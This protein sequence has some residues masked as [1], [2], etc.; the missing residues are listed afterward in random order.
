MSNKNIGLNKAV[1]NLK[2]LRDKLELSII[3][4]NDSNEI[5]ELIESID[6]VTECVNDM[7]VSLLKL[8]ERY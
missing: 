4:G 1:N 6:I 2:V 8:F 3:V 7:N 5:K